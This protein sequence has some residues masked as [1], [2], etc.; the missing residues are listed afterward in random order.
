VIYTLNLKHLGIAALL[1]GCTALAQAVDLESSAVST[2]EN[3][4]NQPAADSP[5]SI[6]VGD[7][8]AQ[9]A[10]TL[11]GTPYQRGAT[12]SKAV[13]C[14]GLVQLSYGA[15]GLGLPRTAAEQSLAGTA[16]TIAEAAPGDL[17]FY[18]FKRS[19]S[20]LHVA[21]YVGEGHAIHASIKHGVVRLVNILS[22][23]WPEHLV[24]VI[25]P[26]A[27]TKPMLVANR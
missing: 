3:V 24:K 2:A 17:L 20:Q 15:A 27:K 19:S 18:R 11:L 12:S 25:H 16:T 8:A 7:L 13:D 1:L 6:R 5:S 14:S 9:V 10:A 4:E 22:G 23:P 21:M 26:A